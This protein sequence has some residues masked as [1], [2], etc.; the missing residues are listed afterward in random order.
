MAIFLLVA[1]FASIF[2]SQPSLAADEG[3]GWIPTWN[4]AQLVAA[5]SNKPILLVAAAPQ[6]AGVP[7]QW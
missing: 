7:G 3:I 1:L 6:C 4:Q 5:R 2:L